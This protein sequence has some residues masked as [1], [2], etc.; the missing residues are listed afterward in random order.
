MWCVCLVQILAITETKWPQVNTGVYS[1][2]KTYIVR[3]DILLAH[4]RV[5][6]GQVL[7]FTMIRLWPQNKNV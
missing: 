5:I 2:A 1:M 3:C 6:F 4:L 7:F